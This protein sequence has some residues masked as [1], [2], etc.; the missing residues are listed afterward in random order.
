MDRQTLN[1]LPMHS[2]IAAGG[3]GGGGG[4]L[5]T[6]PRFKISVDP[7]QLFMK[8][9]LSSSTTGSVSISLHLMIVSDLT[10][11]LSTYQ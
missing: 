5:Y 6:V 4:L 11:I 2:V 3:G 10:I 1:A 8:D 7:N 9:T